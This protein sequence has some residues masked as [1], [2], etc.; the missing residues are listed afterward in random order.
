MGSR[1]LRLRRLLMWIYRRLSRGVHGI[2]LIASFLLDVWIEKV[3]MALTDM[4][5]KIRPLEEGLE[6]VRGST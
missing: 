5:L 1:G 4:Q 3:G 6:A 2:C